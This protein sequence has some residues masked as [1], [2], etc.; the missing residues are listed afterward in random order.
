MSGV[1]TAETL[2]TLADQFEYALLANDGSRL[3]L[4]KDFRYT[5]NGQKLEIGDG[6]WGTLSALAGQDACIFPGATDLTYRISFV[7]GD[8]V[9][10]LIKFD[11]NKVKGVMAMRL[12]ANGGKI[13]EVEIIPV[14]EEFFGD[15]GGTITLLQPAMLVTMDGALVGPP[16]P[17]F[18][19]KVAK[20]EAHDALVKAAEAY[21]KAIISND[22]GAVSFADD[23]RRFDNGQP[24]TN[25]PD[26]KALDP[27][28]PK[29]RPFA[30]SCREQIDSGFFS[31]LKRMRGLRSWA[32]P[33]RGLVMSFFQLDNTGTTLSFDAPGYG[34]VKYPGP[35][36]GAPG[37]IAANE[38]FDGRIT[39][40]M[41][42][43]VTMNCAFL[44]KIEDGKIRRIDAFYRGAPYGMKSGW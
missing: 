9:L 41:T 35:R 25:V 27:D 17:L 37:D 31:N 10:R 30:L 43:P 34:R 16:D 20:P 13:S 22:A 12:K 21:I 7:D 26:A 42:S 4:T 5:E 23:C 33:A 1:A 39:T 11:E 38:Q 19:Q 18:T 40:N 24:T 6:L 28:Q 44:F 8:E 14:R 32:D 36:A 29:Y 2:E 3:P 15:R